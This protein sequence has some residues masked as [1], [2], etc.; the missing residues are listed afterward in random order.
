[1][2]TASSIAS[3]VWRHDRSEL[4]WRPATASD[5]RRQWCSGR[6]GGRWMAREL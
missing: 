1:M 6:P 2:A 5:R 3:V 4:P